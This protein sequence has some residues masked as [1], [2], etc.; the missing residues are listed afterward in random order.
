MRL[1]DPAQRGRLM[2]GVAEAID[3]Y[4]SGATRLAAG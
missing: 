4:F 3:A 2:G 1:T